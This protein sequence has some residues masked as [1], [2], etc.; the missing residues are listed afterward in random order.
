MNKFQNK[1]VAILG[2]GLEGQDV[3]KYFLSIGIKPSILDQ[4]NDLNYL[5]RL[6][7]FDVIVRSPGVYRYK[8]EIVD[9]EK[10]GIIITSPRSHHLSRATKPLDHRPGDLQS[11]RLKYP[12]QS[13]VTPHHCSASKNSRRW[14]RSKSSRSCSFGHHNCNHY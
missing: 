12:R 3:E 7:D 5:S 9:A 4:K 13:S 2:Y 10:S 14:C 1:K 6:K 8:K 11:S